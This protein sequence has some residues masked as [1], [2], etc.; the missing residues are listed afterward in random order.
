MTNSQK[1]AISSHQLNQVLGTITHITLW[2]GARIGRDKLLTDPVRRGMEGW[3]LFG[4]LATVARRAAFCCAGEKGKLRLAATEHRMA[5]ERK[6]LSEGFDKRIEDWQPRVGKYYRREAVVDLASI[7]DICA[8]AHKKYENNGATLRMT[9]DGR[10]SS[11]AIAL[12]DPKMPPE[13]KI[14][15][16]EVAVFAG[17][18]ED[19]EKLR[20]I[21]FIINP[22]QIDFI[23][24]KS[25][26]IRPF[27]KPASPAEVAFSKSK[28]LQDEAWLFFAKE[29]ANGNEQA[30]TIVES[31]EKGRIAGRQTFEQVKSICAPDKQ[32]EDIKFK[33]LF[34]LDTKN[35][36]SDKFYYALHAVTDY[37]G[38]LFRYWFDRFMAGNLRDLPTLDP[39]PE[40]KRLNAKINEFEGKLATLGS[41]LR[42]GLVNRKLK[43]FQ[44]ERKRLEEL[45]SPER[46]QRAE[47]SLEI[48][49]R[50][51][52]SLINIYEIPADAKVDK[53]SVFG[54]ECPR[55]RV[56]ESMVP[57]RIKGLLSEIRRSYAKAMLPNRFYM[58]NLTTLRE[59]LLLILAGLGTV[60]I[61]EKIVHKI[62]WIPGGAVAV[63]GEV[64]ANSCNGIADMLSGAVKKGPKGE[65][66]E[67]A[68]AEHASKSALLWGLLG[69]SIT[70][71]MNLKA[72]STRGARLT[73]SFLHSL[74]GNFTTQTVSQGGVWNT[75]FRKTARALQRMGLLDQKINTNWESFKEV[76]VYNIFRL[77]QTVIGSIAL[78]VSSFAI[79]I[80]GIIEDPS[81]AGMFGGMLLFFTAVMETPLAAVGIGITPAINRNAVRTELSRTIED[82]EKQS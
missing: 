20:S 14:G 6:L 25:S 13:K 74:S 48:V 2:E 60:K 42:R 71:F 77:W 72:V 81:K 38:G 24:K 32:V 65:G 10:P 78:W 47:E 40:R 64:L 56:D 46:K 82:A 18:L 29:L 55:V 62:E 39:T 68:K 76:N 51:S 11:F 41:G 43:G 61:F 53:I 23:A 35:R 3:P 57:E 44:A 22:S 54:R 8:T 5:E 37:Y 52:S 70:A 1:V 7:W 67:Q 27:G 16:G 80:F 36:I 75:L 66:G 17:E 28:T 59:S 21:R 9:L 49:K 50:K 69:G 4:K 15:L 58:Q 19:L 12:R 73:Q 34:V 26:A 79:G 63:F 45:T 30:K 33:G 31:A